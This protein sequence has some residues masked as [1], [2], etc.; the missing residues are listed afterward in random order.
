MVMM[1]P[2]TGFDL[3]Y[4]RNNL[5]ITLWDRVTASSCTFGTLV[6]HLG[7]LNNNATTAL[8]Y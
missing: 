1:H 4:N 7:L 6:Y 2:Y 8:Y 5:L 3:I